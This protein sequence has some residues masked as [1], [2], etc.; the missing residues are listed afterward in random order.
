MIKNYLIP[1]FLFLGFVMATENTQYI[2]LD[3]GYKVWTKK[4]AQGTIPILLLHGGP[5]STHEYFE[6]FEQFLPPAGYQLIFYD[7]LGSYFSDKPNNP[8][9]WTVDRFCEEVE[10]VRKALNLEIFYLY[11]FSWGGI[12]AIEYSLRYQQNLKGLII[13]NAT[14]NMR[15]GESYINQLS[16]RLIKENNNS[17]EQLFYAQHFCRLKPWP[18]PITRTFSH[19]NQQVYDTMEGMCN[20]RITGNLKNWDRWKDLSKIHVPTLLIGAKYD[21]LNPQDTHKMGQLIPHAQVFISQKGSH[22]TFYDD[23]ENYFKAL[24]QFL[25]DTSKNN[26]SRQYEPRSK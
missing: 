4:S 12:L 3:N 5:G 16:E 7:Q 10:Q 8:S 11:G 15:A 13:S 6:C 26:I 25:N 22:L 20:F 1:I 19:K 9:L 2:Q 18:E 14:A 23:Q 17:S 24:L 21:V